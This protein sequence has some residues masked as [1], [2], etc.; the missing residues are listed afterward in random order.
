MAAPV[1]VVLIIGPYWSWLLLVGLLAALGLWEYQNMVFQKGLP[2]W[3]QAFYILTGLFL[4]VGASIAGPDGL[5]GALFFGF[6]V[7]F[8]ATLV[9]APQDVNGLSRLARFAMGWL[10]I[11]YLL[12]YV[13]LIE[14]TSAG[15]RWVFFALLVTIANDAGAFY[16]GKYFG[17]YKLYERVSP[18]K[19]IEGSVGGL[20]GGMLLGTLF[21]LLF[22]GTV[23]AVWLVFLSLL[24]AVTGQIGDLIESLVKRMNGVKDSSNMLP[25]HGGILDR[26]DS[27]LFVF[28]VIWFFVNWI[29]S[30]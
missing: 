25:G 7:V 8:F 16:C 23:S 27:L 2:A 14:R 15:N 17:H 19:T 10:Y 22:L 5:H 12:S 30:R 24:L 21:G 1:V 11:P 9:T 29:K 6:F 20:I 4:P 18:K 13:L 26:L 28:P 3:W